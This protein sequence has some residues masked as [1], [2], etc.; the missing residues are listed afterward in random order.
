MIIGGYAVNPYDFLIKM[1]LLS[2]RDIDLWDVARLDELN[3]K[4]KKK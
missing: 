1:K 3:L 2:R 4:N